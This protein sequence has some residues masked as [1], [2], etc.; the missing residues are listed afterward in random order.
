M[1]EINIARQY[2]MFPHKFE[3][4]DDV[5]VEISKFE[6]RIGTITRCVPYSGFGKAKYNVLLSHNNESILVSENKIKELTPE[7]IADKI[8]EN[9]HRNPD[10]FMDKLHELKNEYEKIYIKPID[11]TNE[12]SDDVPVEKIECIGEPEIVT[13]KGADLINNPAIICDSEVE[14]L[15]NIE[16]K[17]EDIENNIDKKLDKLTKISKLMFVSKFF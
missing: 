10:G 4:Y 5:I 16:T 6:S 14:K 17:V 13:I 11:E 1:M 9:L 12:Q 3:V 15:S 8:K 7:F 2:D